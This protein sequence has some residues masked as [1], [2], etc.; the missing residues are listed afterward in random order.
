MRPRPRNALNMMPQRPGDARRRTSRMRLHGKIVNGLRP[1][2]E[3]DC[4][5][6]NRTIA[7]RGVDM[8]ES[9]IVHGQALAT[10]G[11]VAGRTIYEFRSRGEAYRLTPDMPGT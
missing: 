11:T 10:L 9:R 6:A 2:R 8:T 1:T 3:R 5:A 7:G 4:S